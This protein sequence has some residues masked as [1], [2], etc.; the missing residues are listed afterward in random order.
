MCLVGFVYNIHCQNSYVPCD[1]T[2]LHSD[3]DLHRVINKVLKNNHLINPS[4]RFAK[5]AFE[6]KIDSVGEI[7]SVHIKWSRNIKADAYYYIC[8]NIERR[9]KV[10]FLF[11]RLKENILCDKYV[12]CLFPY[13][14]TIQE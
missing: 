11:D 7:H 12:Y 6:L 9:Y 10:P 4:D 2:I 8:L 3:V 14:S 13:N 5:I 1:K